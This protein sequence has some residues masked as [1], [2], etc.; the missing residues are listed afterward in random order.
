M[1]PLRILHEVTGKGELM[2]EFTTEV[3]GLIVSE[4]VMI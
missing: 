1:A 3:Y 4:R 2:Q